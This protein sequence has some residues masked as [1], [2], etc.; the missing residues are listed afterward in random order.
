MEVFAVLQKVTNKFRPVLSTVMLCVNSCREEFVELRNGATVNSELIDTFC[1][2]MPSSQYTR[3]NMLYV[4]FFTNVTNPRNGFKASVSIGKI[5]PCFMT[6]ILEFT[7]K[8]YVCLH[9][10][11]GS[12]DQNLLPW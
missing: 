2:E 8:Q 10:Y 9:Q 6:V 5:H 12:Q 7:Y 11:C 1:R 4:R 3:D